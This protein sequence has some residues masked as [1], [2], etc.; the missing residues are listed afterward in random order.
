MRANPQGMFKFQDIMAKST[1]K[2]DIAKKFHNLLGKQV[3]ALF[4]GY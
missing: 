2:K 1:N 4:F 3:R